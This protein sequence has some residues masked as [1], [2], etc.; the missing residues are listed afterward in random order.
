MPSDERK[1]TSELSVMIMGTYP[2]KRKSP[3]TRSEDLMII[4]RHTH[5][6]QVCRKQFI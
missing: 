1:C 2:L 6:K 5:T 3:Q 4:M